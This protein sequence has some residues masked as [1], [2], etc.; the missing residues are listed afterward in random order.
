MSSLARFE[1]KPES[2]AVGL[3][4]VSAACL[5]IVGADQAGVVI[6]AESAGL[7]GATLKKPPL[8]GT[9]EGAP[10]EHP[11]IREWLSFTTERAY[12]RS[13]VLAVGV[14]SRS[15]NGGLRDLLRPLRP[16]QPIRGHFHAAAFSYRPLQRGR[17]DLPKTVRSLF[18][19]ETLEGL[20]HLIGDDRP[21]SGVRESEFVRGAC[22]IG[23]IREVVAD[24][25]TA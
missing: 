12:A 3:T 18:K 16:N 23:P 5:D 13:L 17:I 15:E 19:D 4:E 24:R 10:F 2:R 25:G 6:V 14:V 7:A 22:W 1:V 11:E 8:R 20:L 21:T 9:T